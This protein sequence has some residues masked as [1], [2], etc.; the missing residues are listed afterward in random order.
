M[1]MRQTQ[2][3]GLMAVAALVSACASLPDR[4]AALEQAR[5]RYNA[6]AADPQVGRLAAEELERAA[7]ALRHA[8]QAWRDGAP[9]ER[10]DHMAY[11]SA[12]RVTLAQDTAASRAAQAVTASA[13]AE[14]ERLRL[15]MRTAEADQAKAQLAQSQ[16]N[17]ARKDGE[18]A[19]AHAA[20]AMAKANAASAD[21]AAAVANANANAAATAAAAAA[22]REQERLAQREARLRDMQAQLAELQA[23]KTDRG[24]V[25]TLGDVLFNTGKAELLLASQRN[26]DKLAAF[27]RKYPEQ[28]ATIEGYTDS[29]GSAQA[30]QALSERRAQAVLSTL[31]RLGVAAEHLN[32]RAYGEEQPVASNDHSAGRQLNRRVEILFAPQSEAVS[33]L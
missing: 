11:L 32:T 25:V 4:N 13:A 27:F 15:V 26:M 23:R 33:R 29:V 17:E 1:N 22:A 19:S 21:A 2:L 7:T 9:L 31:V 16:R 10:I 8:D 20:T 14:R 5:G 28:R 12:Q 3:I 18:L 6:A 24:V 30:N